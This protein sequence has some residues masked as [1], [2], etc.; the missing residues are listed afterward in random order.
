MQ[1]VTREPTGADADRIADV[2]VASWEETY[3]ELLPAGFFT[4]AYREKRRSMWRGQLSALPDGVMVRVAEVDGD[5][6]GFAW[7]GPSLD[8]EPVSSIQLYSLY[9]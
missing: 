9:V 6:V 2:H 7:V 5:I 8:S 3:T 1:V 4:D